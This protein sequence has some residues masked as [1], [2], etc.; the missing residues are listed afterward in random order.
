MDPIAATALAYTAETVVEGAVG[1]YFVTKPTL[2]LKVHLEHV[3][4]GKNVE[5]AHH[6]LNVIGT[7][8]FVFGG[9]TS[10]DSSSAL[11]SNEVTVLNLNTTEQTTASV[12]RVPCHTAEKE[13]GAP[14]ARARHTSVSARNKMFIFGGEDGQGKPVDEQGRLWVYDPA[15]TSWLFLD[16]PPDTKFPSPRA[17]HASTASDDGNVIFIHGGRDA[18]GKL[19]DDTWAFP[20][21]HGKWTRLSTAHEAARSSPSLAYA[22]NKLWRFGGVTTS[23]GENPQDVLQCLTLPQLEPFVQAGLEPQQEH[24]TS[25]WESVSAG[26]GAT[27]GQGEDSSSRPLYPANRSM[28]ALHHISTGQGREY[29]LVALGEDEAREVTGARY[30]HDMWAYQLPAAMLSGAGVKDAIRENI[31]KV[32]SF[33]G[34]WAPVEITSVDIGDEERKG[35]SWTGRG[36][37]ASAMT[38]TRQFMIWGGIDEKGDVLGDGWI[39]KIATDILPGS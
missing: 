25:G 38:G 23:G 6:S 13:Q 18:D 33:K 31:P 35:G 15:T 32:D 27:T 1:A 10:L 34:Q 24:E 19:L 8:A 39:V 16:P 21:D 4:T 30:L 22:Q 9:R 7:Q 2:P 11:A 14:A 20:L 37:F 17:G 26:E 5:R 28:T 3:A 12:E 29:L 36:A